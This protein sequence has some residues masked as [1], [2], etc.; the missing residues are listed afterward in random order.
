M[1]NAR[2]DLSVIGVDRAVATITGI[3]RD[4]SCIDNIALVIAVASEDRGLGAQ[5][6]VETAIALVI[7]KRGTGKRRVVV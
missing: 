2:R 3:T 6:V 1:C 4:R 5:D 7:G